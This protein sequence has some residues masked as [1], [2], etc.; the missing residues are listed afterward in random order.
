M[1]KVESH[2]QKAAGK[3]PKAFQKAPLRVKLAFQGFAL[4]RLPR[5]RS[6]LGGYLK[7]SR[8]LGQHL[9]MGGYHFGWV[10][11]C[12]V[13]LGQHLGMGQN[14]VTRKWT[15]GFSPCAHLPGFHFGVNNFVTH[16]HVA[17]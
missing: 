9:G 2:R 3:P 13:R 1:F 6:G 8:K 12:F 11:I 4:A 7:G 5:L 16:S 17:S 14:E 10:P 15:A